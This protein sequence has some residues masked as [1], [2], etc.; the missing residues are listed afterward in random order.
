MRSRTKIAFASAVAAATL[1]AVHAV[2]Q[3]TPANPPAG[4]QAPQH[5][6]S[7]PAQPETSPAPQEPRG[8]RGGR[9]GGMGG[10]GMR[11]DR[12]GRGGFAGMSDADRQAFFEARLASIKAGLMLNET[13]QRLWPAVENAVRE[14]AKLRREWRERLQKE[15]TPADPVA[16]MK[17]M[18][19]FQSA[20]GAAL[21]KY[22]DAMRP[23]YDTLNDEQ[24]R[25]LRML[26]RQGQG[27]AMRQGQRGHMHQ[28]W[29]GQRGE[30]RGQYQ[31]RWREHHGEGQGRNWGEGRG[32]RFG[33]G[34]R[35]D[36]GEWRGQ[37]GGEGRGEGRGWRNQDFEGQGFDNPG[38]GDRSQWLR[39]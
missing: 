3:N 14:M 27:M 36:R 10:Q 38:A 26:T 13:Q 25:R 18:G 32:E 6:H 21:T 33:E 29:R 30:E 16:R 24:K 23:L 22:A 5:Q 9:R 17:R 28:H 31:R 11:Q 2:A 15:G 35:G 39:M 37:R 20:R 12:M 7:T 8:E 4:A 19:E 34:R 1:F